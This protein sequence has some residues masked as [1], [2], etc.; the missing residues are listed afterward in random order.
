MTDQAKDSFI[1]IPGQPDKVV[2]LSADSALA[3]TWEN[4]L[5]LGH[6]MEPTICPG[7]RLQIDPLDEIKPGFV[8]T[9]TWRDRLLAH[10]VTK[11]SGGLFWASGDNSLEEEGP[12]SIE[13]AIGRVVACR[14]DGKWRS[15]K[16]R[17]RRIGG[18]V[19]N[20]GLKQL[21][22]AVKR[23][24]FLNEL[25]K[26]GHHDAGVANRMLS[27]L[28]RLSIGEVTIQEVTNPDRILGVYLSA[29]MSDRTILA[30]DLQ[31]D[32]EPAGLRLF[33]ALSSRI[34]PVGSVLLHGPGQKQSRPGFVSGMNVN[35]IARYLQVGTML[36][37]RLEDAGRRAGLKKL[38]ARLPPADKYILSVFEWQGFERVKNKKRAKQKEAHGDEQH[39][40]E[41]YL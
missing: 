6:C 34:G 37:A 9:F 22:R 5:S 31:G 21:R 14:R 23:W 11:V 38:E 13:A 4:C 39:L 28:A 24:P 25:F 32:Q 10:R 41:K 18:L 36:L 1:V 20:R 8:V 17:S 29:N 27:G 40:F 19:Y 16:G 2:L 12:I 15:L 33:S 30:A 35:P 3:Q 26:R 7:D